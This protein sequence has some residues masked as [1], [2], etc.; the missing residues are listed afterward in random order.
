MRFYG[1]IYMVIKKFLFVFLMMTDEDA[2]CRHLLL[3]GRVR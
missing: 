1:F 2:F 3:F